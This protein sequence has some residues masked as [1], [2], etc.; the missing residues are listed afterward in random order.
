MQKTMILEFLM[1][2]IEESIEK[3]SDEDSSGIPRILS[4]T[5]NV[6]RL[7]ARHFGRHMSPDLVT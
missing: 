3:Y 4:S 2:M 1:Q 7:R 5:L 6:L